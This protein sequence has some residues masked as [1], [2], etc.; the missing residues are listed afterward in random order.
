[1]GSLDLEDLA[2]SRLPPSKRH[3]VVR[4]G[5]WAQ[6]KLLHKHCSRHTAPWARNPFLVRHAVWR[7]NSQSVQL[8][9][10]EERMA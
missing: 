3:A 7:V 9:L 6:S 8:T 10:A 4:L 5:Q 1:M 2:T